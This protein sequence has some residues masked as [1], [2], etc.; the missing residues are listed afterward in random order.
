MT[1]LFDSA[2]ATIAWQ[3]TA[4]YVGR[5]RTADQTDKDEAPAAPKP[6]RKPKVSPGARKTP[7]QNPG[8]RRPSTIRPAF[9]PAHIDQGDHA[10]FARARAGACSSSLSC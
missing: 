6:P 1:F 8:P 10:V 2:F 5:K 9:G 4:S 7:S 3:S